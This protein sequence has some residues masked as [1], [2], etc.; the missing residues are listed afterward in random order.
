M[1]APDML[2]EVVGDMPGSIRLLAWDENDALGGG[3]D[4]SE[5]HIV[6]RLGLWK[7]PGEIPRYGFPAVL[8]DS[9][10]FQ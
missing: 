7:G 3:I 2:Q 1:V 9:M 6:A 10:R 4:D 5:D 8:G